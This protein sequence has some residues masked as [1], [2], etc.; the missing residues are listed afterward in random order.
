MSDSAIG[1]YRAPSKPCGGSGHKPKDG[2]TL[3]SLKRL[4]ARCVLLITDEVRMV[5]AQEFA[6]VGIRPDEANG[7]PDIFGWVGVVRCGDFEQIR[8]IGK[9]TLLPPDV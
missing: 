4:F 8:P 2:E 9:K 6:A 1:L 7:G 3:R 5:G